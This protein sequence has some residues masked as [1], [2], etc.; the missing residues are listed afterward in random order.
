MSF[1]QKFSMTI[2]YWWQ[3]IRT[4]FSLSTKKVGC[5]GYL[6][7][8]AL[9][10]LILF[11]L[12]LL[13]NNKIIN[14]QSL[15]NDMVGEAKVATLI[16]IAILIISLLYFLL[17]LFIVPANQFINAK[18]QLEKW[19]KVSVK[20]KTELRPIEQ[21]DHHVGIEITNNEQLDIKNCFGRLVSMKYVKRGS[22]QKNILSKVNPSHLPLTWSGGS[23]EGK[24]D[25]PRGG[26]KKVL[27]I[28]RGKAETIELIFNG[29]QG[30]AIYGREE[31]GIY[32]FEIQIDG[33]IENIEGTT[34]QIEPIKIDGYI[35]F[36][37][38]YVDFEDPKTASSTD[39][40]KLTEMPDGSLLPTKEE[41]FRYVFSIEFG[42]PYQ[43]WAK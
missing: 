23:H 43:S 40:E 26:G 3:I 15:I 29:L 27:N 21:E 41:F 32:L 20:V 33:E 34:K 6:A 37:R 36:Q 35:Q 38:Y 42:E 8:T 28:A 1:R 11:G 39:G 31:Q 12:K 22:G 25:I 19:E 4:A 5:I 10:F 30:E 24:L 14:D 2:S 9:T 17:L 13:S 7:T 16:L 18:K